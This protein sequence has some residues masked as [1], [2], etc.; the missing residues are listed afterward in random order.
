MKILDLLMKTKAIPSRSEAR[1]LVAQ[2]AVK[3]DGQPVPV[4]DD[5]V[6]DGK[7]EIHIGR[8]QRFEVVVEKELT[9]PDLERC[10]ADKPNG[11]TFMTLGGR[12]GLE[13]CKDKPTVIVHEKKPGKDGLMGSMSLCTHCLIQFMQ[14]VCPKD[15][16]YEFEEIQEKK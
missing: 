9:P 8:T 16:D 4:W 3:L 2:G 12:P 6:L 11:H 5:E 13:R 14:Q 1:R 10:Q 15:G 7:H